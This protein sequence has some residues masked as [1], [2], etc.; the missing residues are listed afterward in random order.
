MK[1]G[2]IDIIFYLKYRFWMTSVR[3]IISKIKEDSRLIKTFKTFNRRYKKRVRN[4]LN[5]YMYVL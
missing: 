3:T 1:Y 2:Y 5:F 4:G